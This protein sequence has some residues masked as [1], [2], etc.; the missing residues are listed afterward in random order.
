MPVFKSDVE[1][2]KDSNITL[3][4]QVAVKEQFT[5][6]GPVVSACLDISVA[7]KYQILSFES[8]Q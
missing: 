5:R 1:G 6:F 4:G 2:E 7:T 3:V 8:R